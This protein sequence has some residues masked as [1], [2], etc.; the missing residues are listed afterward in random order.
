MI[1]CFYMQPSTYTLNLPEIIQIENRFYANDYAGHEHNPD[2]QIIKGSIPILVAAPHAVTHPRHNAIKKAEA[3][4][5]TIATQ[6]ATITGS[7]GLI[8]AKMNDEDPNFDASG[9][10]KST[11]KD[12]IVQHNIQCVINLHGMANTHDWDLVFGSNRGNSLGKQPHFLSLAVRSMHDAGIKRI[13]VDDAS[14]FNASHPSN[15]SAFSWGECQTPSFQI[16]VNRDYR[17][18]TH[19]PHNFIQ[20]MNGLTLA[21]KNIA[22]SIDN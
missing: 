18:P 22:K 13:L 6:L 17:N 1:E 19:K 16:E 9:P 10:F 5:G 20:L 2:I 15:L 21:I 3:L 7:F 14:L 12:V 11:L 4:T 8:T